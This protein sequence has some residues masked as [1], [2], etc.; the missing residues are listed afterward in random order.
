M[1]IFSLYTLIFAPIFAILLLFSPFV[2]NEE[3]SI[4]RFA[5]GFSGVQFLYSLIFLFSKQSLFLSLP[6]IPQLGINFSF[7]LDGLSLVLCILTTFL[8]FLA[9]IASKNAITKQY[10]FYYSMIMLLTTAIL[11]VFCARDLFLFFLFWELE[12]IP[13]YFLISIWGSG[14]KH[15]SAMKFVLYTFFGSLFMLGSILALAYF[16]FLS[17][18]VLSF[19]MSALNTDNFHNFSTFTGMVIFLGFFVGFAVKLPVVPFHTW[20]PD[21][22]VDAP[23]PVSMLLAGILLKMGGYGLLRI[24]FQ[25]MLA[26]FKYF[27]PFI[28][29]L[30]AINILYAAFVAIAQKDFKKLVAYS[31]V[32]HM[33]I[34]LLGLA[35]CNTAGISGAVLQMVAHGV[36]SA[37]LF[38]IVGVIYLRTKT[39][40][41]ADLGGLAQVAP[42]LF[43]FSMIIALAGLGLPLLIA[44]PAEALAFYGAATSVI[45][46]ANLSI[47]AVAVIS[48]VGIIF[49]SVYILLM[50]QKV[51]FGNIF[52]KWQKFRDISMSEGVVLGLISFVIVVFGF[53]PALVLNT[54]TSVVFGMAK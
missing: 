19:D 50:M 16:H 32:S 38:M 37:G 44:F 8:V 3:T 10:K 29:L 11:G 31:S 39:R 23:T 52:A 48:A 51:F 45:R 27:A 34:V 21:A 24:N 30:A 46:S 43:S 36:I 6:W 15:Y 20:L 14:R 9:C 28:A 7:G 47:P 4:R 18:G 42:Q 22:H 2:K 17:T 49:T 12:L 54:F 33:G 26:V 13:M 41:F 35:A 5:I 1:S 53:Y 25:L 40:Q